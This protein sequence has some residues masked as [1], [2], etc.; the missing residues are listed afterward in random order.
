MKLFVSVI[1]GVPQAFLNYR[2][3]STVGWSIHNV[4]CDF[5]GGV[6]SVLQLL[7]DCAVTNDWGGINGNALKFYL[8]LFSIAFDL[9]FMIQHFVLYPTSATAVTPSKW[10]K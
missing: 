9:L 8:G 3:K 4:L 1:K 6:F 10:T 5:T 7:V 2:R